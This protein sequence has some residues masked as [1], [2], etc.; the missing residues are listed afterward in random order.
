MA[1]DLADPNAPESLFEELRERVTV[2]IL[3]NNAGY[4]SSEN[5]PTFR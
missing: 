4:G 5:S 3:I 2:D 1:L